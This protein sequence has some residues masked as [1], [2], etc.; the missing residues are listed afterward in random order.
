VRVRLAGGERT[1]PAWLYGLSGALM[2]GGPI[3]RE[4]YF[5]HYPARPEAFLLPLIAATLG[6][7]VAIGSRFAGGLLGTIVFG[8][9]LF[10]FADLQFDPQR[11]TYTAVV[12]VGCIGLAQ[13][14]V[15]HR[16]AIFALT[17]GAF[18]VTSLVRPAVAP[19]PA[20]LD[21][22]GP[23]RSTNPLLVHIVFDGQWGVGG[24]RAAGDTVTA[25]FL[26]DFYLTRGFELYEAAYSRYRVTIESFRAL[27][28]LGDTGTDA[29]PRRLPFQYSLPQNPYFDRLRELGYAIRVQETTYIDFCNGET[30]VASCGVQSGNSI[31]NVGFLDGSWVPRGILTL[32]YFLATRSH[33]FN[34]LMAAEERGRRALAGGAV[35][36]MRDLSAAIAT[37][38][39]GG[40][41]WFVHVMTPHRPFQADE[42][43]RTQT[44]PSRY[45]DFE[46]PAHPSDSLWRAVMGVYT[47]QVRCT[48]RLLADV[49]DAIDS[50]VGRDRSIVIVHGDHGSRLHA[51]ALH[52]SEQPLASYSGS[53]L[54]TDF[55][56]M[57]AIR[58]PHF[59][60]ALRPEPVPVQDVIRYLVESGFTAAVP[61]TWV[62]QLRKWPDHPQDAEEVRPLSIS[63]MPWAQ[64]PD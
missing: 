45:L 12:L 15:R 1:E 64:P 6:A 36:A 27:M 16:A 3:A 61:T 13:L 52:D 38:P 5:H 2:L 33:I 41:A 59:P 57:L 48:H 54:N 63:E 7:I 50:T 24:F 31:A 39:S 46:L 49:I 60:A 35:A 29:P 4:L 9:L 25:E 40:T 20:R 19:P 28:F 42:N 14:L 26:K 18:Y 58:R 34:K 32:Q 21:T 37:N 23:S 47:D 30:A 17:L 62:H 56:T 55:S 43:C 22:S 8:G 10:A 51:Q 53:E 44:A 11:W